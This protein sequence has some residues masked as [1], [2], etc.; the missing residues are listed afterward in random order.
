MKLTRIVLLYLILCFLGSF[1]ICAAIWANLLGPMQI[2]L[3]TN[4]ELE[5]AIV[6]FLGG[7][8]GGS[9]YC[10]RVFHQMYTSGLLD[11]ERY[12]I[13]YVLRPMF[14]GGT[15]V[16]TVI[17]L[18]SGILIFTIEDTVQAKIGLSFLVGYGFG[19]LTHK[20]E[21]TINTMFGESEQTSSTKAKE[22]KGEQ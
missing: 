7:L 6:Y 12:W 8:I 14:S 16:M 5:I 20:L 18:E 4:P 17:L 11:I 9:L 19:K 22:T 3:D 15:A 21:S 1:I 13:W 10:M 2:L